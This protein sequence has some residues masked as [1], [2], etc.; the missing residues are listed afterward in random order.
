MS[1]PGCSFVSVF[2]MTNDTRNRTGIL[3]RII[4]VM[5]GFGVATLG[6][7][8]IMTAILAFIGLPL[9]FIGL[10]LVQAQES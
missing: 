4:L 10:A 1:Q 8:L 6:W 5:V 3:W 2:D 7:T 9:F